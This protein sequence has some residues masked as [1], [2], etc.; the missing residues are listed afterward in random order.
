MPAEQCLLPGWC[1]CAGAQLCWGQQRALGCPLHH[2][3]QQQTLC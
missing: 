2:L 3:L 1:W